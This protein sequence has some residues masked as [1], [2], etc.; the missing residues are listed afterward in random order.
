MNRN[1]A[2]TVHVDAMVITIMNITNTIIITSTGRTANAVVKIMNMS[3]VMSIAT[4]IPMPTALPTPIPTSMCTIIP[5]VTGTATNRTI[6][7]TADVPAQRAA[8][9]T[10]RA[11]TWIPGPKWWH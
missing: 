6:T 11:A 10:A 9:P 4:S 5:T 1:M 7:P 2:K 8:I 3:T